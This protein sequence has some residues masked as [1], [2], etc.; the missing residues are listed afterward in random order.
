MYCGYRR[1]VSSFLYMSTPS[2]EQLKR[3]IV[4]LEQID[5]LEADLKAVLSG[6]E[7]TTVPGQASPVV[8]PSKKRK[9]SAAG[10]ANIIAAQKA[11]W[12]KINGSKVATTDQPA[13]TA[14]APKAG[15]KKAKRNISPESR[16]K[17]AA[18]AKKRWAKAKK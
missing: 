7:S 6:A 3:A 14:K 4:I 1:K 10:R 18:A 11:R 5:K 8:K 15:K 2:T 16:A 17:M 12:D 9:M 13:P